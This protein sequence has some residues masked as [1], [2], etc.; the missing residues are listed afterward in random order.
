MRV[1]GYFFI[2]KEYIWTCRLRYFCIKQEFKI[3][4]YNHWLCLNIFFF[5]KE[6]NIKEN[7]FHLYHLTFYEIL[8]KHVI[9][10]NIPLTTQSNECY[11]DKLGDWQRF[12]FS[13]LFLD[14]WTI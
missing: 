12:H 3:D 13:A 5:Q 11:V 8:K 4:K 14:F 2:K 7:S 10:I 1:H 6:L 9:V